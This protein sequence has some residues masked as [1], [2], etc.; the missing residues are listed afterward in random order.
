MRCVCQAPPLSVSSDRWF[1]GFKSLQKAPQPEAPGDFPLLER[2]C[3][4]KKNGFLSCWLRGLKLM[5]PLPDLS[6]SFTS[7]SNRFMCLQAHLHPLFPH[8]EP[9]STKM[10]QAKWGQAK[11]KTPPSN[12]PR[13]IRHLHGC[14]VEG[15]LVLL[16]LLPS[17][18]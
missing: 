18:N 7:T 10:I 4:A 3:E 16:Q 14:K 2:V 17:E 6:T 15:T 9:K 5:G 12:Q 8:T 13:D 11:N 1:I